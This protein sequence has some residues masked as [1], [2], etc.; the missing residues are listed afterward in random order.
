MSKD[1]ASVDV[2]VRIS[3]IISPRCNRLENKTPGENTCE[4]F[5]KQKR[6]WVELSERLKRGFTMW[7]SHF[8]NQLRNGKTA[9][10]IRNEAA[11]ASQ[12]YSV[13]A[14]PSVAR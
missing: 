5:H 14:I 8:R 4:Q 7:R 1:K 10:I 12:N 6:I 11:A 13:I 2:Q 9:D 3:R